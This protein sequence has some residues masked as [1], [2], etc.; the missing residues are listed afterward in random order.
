[1]SIGATITSKVTE[2]KSY[3]ENYLACCLSVYYTHHLVNMKFGRPAFKALQKI[4]DEN[5]AP[6]AKNGDQLD[7]NLSQE[8]ILKF[9][10][11][12]LD[13]LE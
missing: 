3:F 2:I 5:F 10:A 4:G 13:L 12:T 7:E 6:L 1:M 11:T 9:I 8:T